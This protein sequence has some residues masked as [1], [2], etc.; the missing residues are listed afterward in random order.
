MEWN[1]IMG[2]KLYRDLHAQ[3]KIA[4]VLNR[5]DETERRRESK[6]NDK[7]KWRVSIDE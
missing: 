1:G 6:S 7:V 2:K 4:R 5:D 3:R